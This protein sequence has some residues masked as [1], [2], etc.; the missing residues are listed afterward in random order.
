MENLSR[1]PGY[2]YRSALLY[3]DGVRSMKLP[4]TCECGKAFEASEN[5]PSVNLAAAR[6]AGLTSIKFECK[7]CRRWVDFNPVTGKP[8]KSRASVKAHRCPVAGCAGWVSRVKEEGEK[9]FWGCGECGS[10]WFRVSNLLK[11]VDQIIRRYPYRKHCYVKTD[12]KW[13]PGDSDNEPRGYE[14]KIGRE[15]PDE[16]NEYLRG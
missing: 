9:P 14:A 7:N 3:S 12:G 10:V 6:K 11:E 5:C 2:A 16:S 1:V 4:F 15:E 8:N 13:Q